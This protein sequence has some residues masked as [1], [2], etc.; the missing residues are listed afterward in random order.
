ME[1][2][3]A[4]MADFT[5]AP[6]W[7]P[8]S[9]SARRVGRDHVVVVARFFGSSIELDYRVVESEPPHLVVVAVDGDHVRGRDTISISEDPDTGRTRLRYQAELATTGT[10]RLFSPLVGLG[11]AV[12]ARRALA[13]LAGALDG[14]V[15][16]CR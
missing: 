3:H 13:G 16:D 10:R 8:G 15:V 2:V 4:Y 6:A 12:V 14:E 7:D 1:E 11:F 5:N 9:E